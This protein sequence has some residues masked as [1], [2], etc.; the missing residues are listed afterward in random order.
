MII[1]K[2][3]AALSGEG[4]VDVIKSQE[5]EACLVQK[6]FYLQ[7]RTAVFLYIEDDAIQSAETLV[8]VSMPF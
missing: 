3:F 1:E 4:T 5:W 6:L 7:S 8:M 2:L